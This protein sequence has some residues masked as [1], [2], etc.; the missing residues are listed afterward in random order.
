[1]STDLVQGRAPDLPHPTVA[2]LRPLAQREA[3]RTLTSPAL[4]IVGVYFV[5][6]IGLSGIAGEHWSRALLA[7]FAGVIGVFFAIAVFP[8]VHLTAT[9][10]RRTGAEAQLAATPQGPLNRDL[11]LCLAVVLGPGLVALVTALLGKW[12]AGDGVEDRVNDIQMDPWTLTD[13]LQLPALAIGA[14]ILA[15]VVAR[16]LPF[17][18]SL[19]IG[20]FGMMFL[21]LWVADQGKFAW[22]SWFVVSAESVEESLIAPTEYLVWHTAYLFAWSVLGVSAIGIR[23]AS[24]KRGWIIAFAVSLAAVAVTGL[25]QIPTYAANYVVSLF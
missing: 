1:V 6:T 23:Q 16:W 22:L 14:G 4:A 19:L 17:P 5:L 25:L 2:G 11:A 8:A 15:V 24:R 9:S 18:G 3:W 21:T 20:L 7:E 12:A 10:A 13:V